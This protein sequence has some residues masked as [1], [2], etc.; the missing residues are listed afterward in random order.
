MQL[1]LHEG[2]SST[3]LE[4][5][6][7]LR[8]LTGFA[9]MTPNEVMAIAESSTDRYFA[10]GSE[11]YAEGQPIRSIHYVLDGAVAIRRK[12]VTLSVLEAPA[13]VGA[14][15]SLAELSDGQQM[16]ADRDCWALEMPSDAMIE[17]FEDNFPLLSLVMGS[18]ASGFI[19]ARKEAGPN[20]GFDQTIAPA[21]P[22]A[23]PLGLVEKLF[24]LHKSIQFASGRIEM[25]TGLARTADERR[26]KAGT[27]LWTRGE[28]TGS[29]LVL[30]SGVI[31]CENDDQ[32]FRF[33]P[34]DSVGGL[35]ALARQ[36]RW[37]DARAET[38][39]V[40][41]ELHSDVLVDLFEDNVDLAISVTR[42]LARML[43][44]K[45]EENARMR[46]AERRGS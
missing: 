15:G 37:Y 11:I 28:S 6:L 3:Q 8:T 40:A 10:R 35:D 36:P 34:G 31:A 43:I 22:P 2:M 4:R 14:L 45:Q 20:A 33:G 30:I 42:R 44:A 24:Y 9:H 7:R 38:D 41:L 19:D 21:D 5:V 39:L 12:G 27:R 46:S 17:V 25:L 26:V 29:W 13:V 18:I 32:Q 1:E 23:G 16:V